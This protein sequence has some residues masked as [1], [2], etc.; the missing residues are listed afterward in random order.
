MEQH[1]KELLA[2][3]RYTVKSSSVLQ[4]LDRKIL[5]L[6]YQPLLGSKCFSLYM[7]LWGELEQNRLWGEEMTHHSLMMIMQC[8]LREIY[9][10]RLKLEGLGLLKTYLSETSEFKRYVYELQA[11]LR[12]N[13]FFQDGVLNIYLYNRVGK[14]KFAQLKRFFSDQQI[15][16]EMKDITRS[17]NEIFDSGQSVDMIA[18]VN[19]ETLADLSLAD[20]RDYMQ[21]TKR[22]EMD[23]SDDVFD[24][25]LFFTGLSE[26][27][28]P[29]KA[30]TPSVKDVIK[31]LSYLYGINA[32][33]MKNVVMNSIDQDDIIDIELLRKS[34]R[35]WYQFQY[36]DTLPGL[37]DKT[38][39]QHLQTTIEKKQRTKEEE[40]IYQL[41]TISPRQFLTDVSGG[42]PPA[43]GDM[44]I[45]EEVML[46]QRL[47]PGVVNVLIYYVMLK[48]DMKLTRA[49]VQKIAGHWTRKQI[50]TVRAAMDLAKHEHRQ[51]QQWAEEKAT[52]KST[53]AKKAPIRK[54]MLPSWLKEDDNDEST[55]DETKD[56]NEQLHIDQEQFELE[57]Q[58]L[59]DRI[60]KYKD[61]K[62]NT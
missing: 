62:S 49:Y 60:K 52:K 17:F 26:A 46:Q 16:H 35:D 28:I 18:R 50:T 54:E 32:V 27:I 30:I 40:M 48:T 8:N 3:D 58:K 31:K 25:E 42:R 33:D 24:F 14:N 57:K 22:A 7:T 37:L 11:P 23:I 53:S 6:L 51:Y 41:E 1:W 2:I 61:N 9:R 56:K 39:P 13:E 12:P 43:V 20:D 45:I 29:K 44:Q 59:F 34:S 21:T 4:D 19:E 55:K 47:E 38:Q 15:D 36:G 10:E 5:T